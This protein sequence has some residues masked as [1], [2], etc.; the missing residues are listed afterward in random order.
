MKK[1]LFTMFVFVIMAAMLLSAC[2]PAPAQHPQAP[3]EPAQPPAEPAQPPAEPAAAPGTPKMGGSLVMARDSE[4]IS[5]DPM[6][7]NDNGSIFMAMQIFDGLVEVKDSDLP[8]PQA[9]LAETWKASDDSKTW[10][11]KLRQGAKFSNGDPVTCDDVKFSIDRFAN[12]EVN[13][14]YTGFGSSIESTKCEDAATFVIQLN[15]VEGAFL[16]YLATLT[17][18]IISKKAYEQM[19]ET[20]FGEKPIGSGPFM[21]KEWI[22][23]QR[24]VLERNPYYWQEGKPYLDS[25]VVEYIPDDNTRM[26][27]IESGEADIATEVPYSQLERI[28]SL[29]GIQVLIEDVMAWDAVWFNVKKP[30]L[31]DIKVIQALNYAAPKEAMLKTLM[32]GA[33]EIANHVIAKVK[34]WDPAVPVYP[35]DLEKAKQLMAE[36]SSPQGFSMNCLIV[37]GDQSER[38]QAEVLQQEWAKIGVKM[39]IEAVDVS[40]IW[41]RWGKGDEMCF[42][43]PGAG[44]SSDALSD[45]NLAVVF[46]DMTGGAQSF[47][48]NWDSKEATALVK[49]AGSSIDENVRKTA[50]QKL[51]KLVMEEYPAVPLFFIK[52]RT[53]LTNEV[54]GFKTLPVKWWNL[55]NVWLDK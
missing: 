3:A 24:L 32:Y 47:W 7:G 36:S 29:S 45:D 34:Y 15:R 39:E 18:L 2:A 49:E 10:T 52:A 22:R 54:K 21:V 12:P 41:E 50:F 16:D 33:G 42:T 11:F 37:S 8:Q 4:P 27:K 9:G 25:I 53:A 30:P 13:T 43:Y 19:G 17:P 6:K 20:A 28:K 48:T 35:Y 1:I 51:Q 46:F 55:E 26:L 31:N 38:Q 44:L 40:T 23:G 5:L 14:L